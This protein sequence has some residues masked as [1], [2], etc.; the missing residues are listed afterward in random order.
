M[1]LKHLTIINKY[2]GGFTERE[3][4]KIH[5][6]LTSSENLE[7]EVLMTPN[8]STL[9]PSLWARRDIKPD[10]LG[11]GGG[12]GTA[13]ILSLVEKIWGFLPEYIAPFAMGTMNNYALTFGLSD[14]FRDKIKHQTGFG[15]TKAVQ[16]ARYIRDTLDRGEELRTGELGL[17]KVSRRGEN[18]QREASKRSAFNVGFGLTPKLIWLYYG[19]TIEQYRELQRRL[20]FYQ[21]EEFEDIV[22]SVF[23]ERSTLDG[24]VEIFTVGHSELLPKIPVLNVAKAIRVGVTGA[25]GFSARESEFINERMEGSIRLDGEEIKLRYGFHLP[26]DSQK[27]LGMYIASYEHSNLGIASLSPKILPEARCV[28]GKMQVLIG[29]GTPIDL[30]KEVYKFWQGRH[31]NCSDYRHAAKIEI[32]SDTPFAYQVDGDIQFAKQ[33]MVEY[34]KKVKIVSL[35]EDL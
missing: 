20:Q 15:D 34:H 6:I 2:A 24:L 27:P 19:K 11:I 23:S 18:D 14:G 29:K 1:K 32:E 3:V 16:L 28:E 8:L 5:N 17:F 13:R 21:P 26:L 9:A 4:G 31:L 22:K 25:L 35:R 10:I 30:L 12:D 7:G 33:V